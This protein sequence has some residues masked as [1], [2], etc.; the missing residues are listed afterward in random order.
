[1]VLLLVVS[2]FVMYP[3]FKPSEN[4]LYTIKHE[5]T[6]FY[7]EKNLYLYEDNAGSE[8]LSEIAEG[9]QLYR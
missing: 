4:S 6:S 9:G 5:I 3:L 8:T 1:M 2:V 7:K